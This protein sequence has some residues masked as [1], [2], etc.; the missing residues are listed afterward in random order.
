MLISKLLIG[1]LQSA[2]KSGYKTIKLLYCVA[3]LNNF[4]VLIYYL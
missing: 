3:V 1:N 2:K 4:V